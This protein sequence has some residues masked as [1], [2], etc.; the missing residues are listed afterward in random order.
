MKS[1]VALRAGTGAGRGAD[2]GAAAVAA[3]GAAVSGAAV[4][5]VAVAGAPQA[6]LARAR[7]VPACSLRSVSGVYGACG[8]ARHRRGWFAFLSVP[9]SRLVV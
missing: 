8:R 6:L 4:S 1:G 3:D 7:A 2:I 9:V 5:G